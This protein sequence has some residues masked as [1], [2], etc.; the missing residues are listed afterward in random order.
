MRLKKNIN[1]NNMIDKVLESKLN[2]GSSKKFWNPKIKAYLTMIVKKTCLFD[3]IKLSTLLKQTSQPLSFL[4]STNKK[5]VLVKIPKKWELAYKSLAKENS[6]DLLN[7]SQ[8]NL[9]FSKK[10]KVLI[11]S[12]QSLTKDFELKVKASDLPSLFPVNS[13]DKLDGIDYPL[14]GNLSSF[15]GSSF[16][17]FL[18]KAVLRKNKIKKG[19]IAIIH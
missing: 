17:Y 4:I 11:F 6:F 15:E 3:V 8:E 13:G 9:V 16:P 1:S 7:E 18:L 14:M 2:I 12:G 5:L 19:K 10:K